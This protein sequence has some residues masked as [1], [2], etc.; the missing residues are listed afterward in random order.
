[1]IQSVFPVLPALIV[2]HAWMTMI[3]VHTLSDMESF[4]LPPETFPI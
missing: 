3:I 2:A 4:A 1:M